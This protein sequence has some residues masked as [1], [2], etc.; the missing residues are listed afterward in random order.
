MHVGSVLLFEG[1]AARVRRPR[2]ADRAAAARSFP[3]T[4][5][6]SPSRRSCRAGRCGSTTRTSTPATTCATPRCRAPAG[7]AELRRLAGRVFAQRLD[8][9]KPLWEIWL[10][11]RV[12]DDRFALIAKTHHCLVDGVSGVDIA[13]VLFDLDARPAARSP[14]RSRGSRG[15]SRAPAKLLA[16]A[17]VERAHTPLEFAGAAV[18]AVVHPRHAAMRGADRGR[19]AGGDRAG[20]ARRRAGARRST[21]GSARTGASRGSTPT[22]RRSRRSRTRSAGR[23]TTSC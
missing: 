20:G 12:G 13:T 21:S 5:R 9:A 2:R 10:V 19:R 18:D 6:S 15:P 17:L 3:A 1:D 4:A 8:R 22:W 16:D 23:S 7:E 14:T 11:D